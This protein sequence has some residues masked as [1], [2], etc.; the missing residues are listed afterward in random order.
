MNEE[1]QWEIGK[2]YI[3]MIFLKINVF[4]ILE[5]KCK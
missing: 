2:K 5:Y 3:S 4:L 1:N